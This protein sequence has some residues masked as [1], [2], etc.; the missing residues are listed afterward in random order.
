MK[1]VMSAPIFQA[2]DP[3]CQSGATPLIPTIPGVLMQLDI[4]WS[5]TQMLF[6]IK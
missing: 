6:C 1:D 3:S 4:G 5:W 2:I